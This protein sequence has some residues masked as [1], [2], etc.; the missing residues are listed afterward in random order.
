VPR[1]KLKIFPAFF[2]M[3]LQCAKISDLYFS[4]FDAP[5]LVAIHH[6]EG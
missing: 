1:H 3:R 6:V 2:F 4:S 5:L